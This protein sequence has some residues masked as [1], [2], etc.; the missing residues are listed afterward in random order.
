MLI[1]PAPDAPEGA[2]IAAEEDPLD[3]VTLVDTATVALAGASCIP[4]LWPAA[5]RLLIAR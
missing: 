4:E 5:A 2:P 3:D 1:P